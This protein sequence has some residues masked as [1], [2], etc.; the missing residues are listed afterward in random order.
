MKDNAINIL[1]T[2][3]VFIK[4][5]IGSF[6]SDELKG[7]IKSHDFT[8]CD[9]EGSV[10]TPDSKPAKKAGP[11][12]RQNADASEI[13]LNEGFNI[14][15]LANNHIYDYGEEGLKNTLNKFT[16]IITLG[17]GL[18]F[19][20]AYKAKFVSKGDTKIGFLSFGESEFGALTDNLQNKGGFAWINHH[21]VNSLITK[22]KKECDILI[23]MAHAGI[24]QI[25]YP[26]PEWRQ[27]YYEL[28]DTG[29]DAIIGC[30]VHVPQ[31]WEIY[32]NKPIFYSIGN[33]FFDMP[34]NQP[35][36]N[37]GYSVSLNISEKKITNFEVIPIIKK[38]NIVHI[39]KD[40]SYDKHLE[41]LCDIL[42]SP[43]YIDNVNKICLELWDK[44]YK[45]Y[46][47][48]AMGWSYFKFSW[49]DILSVIKNK[50]FNK[51]FP[52]QPAFSFDISYI[53]HNIRI[54]SHRWA[55][56]RALS[57]LNDKKLI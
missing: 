46:Y 36:W 34:V 38:D 40:A 47:I 41:Y 20:S 14:M 55:V 43:D 4:E 17:A 2:G 35:L 5:T 27:R 11:H 22:A 57:L 33:F 49:K 3:D 31:G 28:I 48:E 21:S 24:E 8:V 44:R 6:L 10:D 42:N 51:K 23:V 16:N 52:I 54:E 13:V 45:K 30:H 53:L 26:L 19:N 39:L 18:D 56:I 9:F 37:K 29:A 15:N 25:D 50:V 7:L 12:I 32:K 1:F